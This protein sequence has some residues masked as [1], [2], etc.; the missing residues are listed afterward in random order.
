MK[1]VAQL[2]LTA[3]LNSLTLAIDM[4]PDEFGAH[5]AEVWIWD[6]SLEC[7]YIFK[8]SRDAESLNTV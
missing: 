8:F 1:Y 6:T 3:T 7:I 4:S 2:Y 5:W